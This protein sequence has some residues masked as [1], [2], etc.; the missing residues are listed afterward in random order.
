MEKFTSEQMLGIARHHL[1]ATLTTLETR[2]HD[3]LDFH[4]VSIWGIRNALQAAY[5]LGAKEGK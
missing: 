1:D 5:D 4:E 3:D 2:N